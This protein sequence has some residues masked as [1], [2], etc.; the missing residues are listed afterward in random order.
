MFG[1]T[2]THNTNGRHW[3]GLR[4]RIE[5]KLRIE[6]EWLDQL[7]SPAHLRNLVEESE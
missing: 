5:G 1:Y 2:P 6:F 7:K 4:D 3:C